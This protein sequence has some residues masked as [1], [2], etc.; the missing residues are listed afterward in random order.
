MLFRSLVAADRR[1]AAGLT[2]L[3]GTDCRTRSGHLPHAGERLDAG[4]DLL[5]VGNNLK[6]Q[7]EAL[8]AGVA[9]IEEL[10]QE[11]RITEARLAASIARVE[12][13][14]RGPLADRARNSAA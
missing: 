5:L 11:G 13:L 7:P 3:S 1:T 10:L 4:A 2:R 6:D 9:A 8:T 14:A 12:R